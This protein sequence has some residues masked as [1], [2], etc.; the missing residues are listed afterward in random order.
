MIA[1][2]RGGDRRLDQIGIDRPRLGCHVD[3]DGQRARGHR[4]VRR[5]GERQRGDDH[6]VAPPDAR[7]PCTRPPSSRCRSS[8]GCRGGAL[9]GGERLSKAPPCSPG[10]G[11]PPQSP[12][13][14]TA[15]TAATYSSSSVWGQDR[16]GRRAD[17]GAAVDRKRCHGAQLLPRALLRWVASV[18]RILAL[19]ASRCGG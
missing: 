11:K 3:D 15:V 5:R 2:V 17:R 8:S 9:V 6:L 18:S 13:R 14:T 16:I 10:S 4:R 12:L 1:R 19:T 7:G